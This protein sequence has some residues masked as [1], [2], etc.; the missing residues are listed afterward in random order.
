MDISAMSM[1]AALAVGLSGL[2]VAL[3]EAA[4]A[5]SSL[6]IMGKSPRLSGT[7]MIFTVLGV[8]LV[9]TAVIYGLVVAFSIIG[10]TA[11]D[12][13]L[14]AAGLVIGLTGFGAGLGEGMLLAKA[15]E[16]VNRNPDNKNQILQF[17][18]LFAALVETSAIY[19]LTVA[20]KL[21]G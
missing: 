11:G 9:E 21:I 8:A 4:L 6:E 7:M 12:A 2:G 10:S 14:I 17:M 19:G 20:M 13:N 16:A 15:L 3:G 18:V 1:G 5:R